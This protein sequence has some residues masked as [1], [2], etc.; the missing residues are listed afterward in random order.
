MIKEKVIYGMEIMNK[1]LKYY[2][3][4]DQLNKADITEREKCI[5][6]YRLM[7]MTL[8][9]VAKLYTNESTKKPIT[10]ER[11]RQIEKRA[12]RKLYHNSRYFSQNGERKCIVQLL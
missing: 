8:L 7:G 3:E 6:K 5:L 4:F 11:I 2:I 10:S 12:L 1:R 9:E